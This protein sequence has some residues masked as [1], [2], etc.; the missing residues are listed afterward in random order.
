MQKYCSA[1]K[2]G[3]NF[4]FCVSLTNQI[5]PI[6]FLLDTGTICII[7]YFLVISILLC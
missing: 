5:K 1:K 6:K 3:K 7:K 2:Q 4:P